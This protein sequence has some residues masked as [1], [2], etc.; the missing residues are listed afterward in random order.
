MIKTLTKEESKLLIKIMPDYIEHLNNYPNSLLVRFCGMHRVKMN[1]NALSSS[2]APP[3]YFVIM[4]SVFDT[5]K[6]IHS[7]YDL[8]VR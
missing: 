2:S 3:N 8:K 5:T 1:F 4:T 7:V 6:T